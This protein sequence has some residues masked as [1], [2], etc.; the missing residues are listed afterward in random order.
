MNATMLLLLSA[1][2]L[3]SDPPAEAN[4]DVPNSLLQLELEEGRRTEK[5]EVEK[6]I[7]A[8]KEL[9]QRLEGL[10]VKGQVDDLVAGR[11]YRCMRVFPSRAYCQ[12]VARNLGMGH[13]FLNYVAAV[14]T[15]PGNIRGDITQEQ[16]ESLKHF[17]ELRGKCSASVTN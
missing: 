9:Q 13:S 5:L 7:A 17:Y 12:C 14:S 11:T 3:Q 15:P 1:V 10:N 2:L 6:N 4:M 16:K 8:L